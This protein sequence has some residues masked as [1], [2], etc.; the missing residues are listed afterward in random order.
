MTSSRSRR[1]AL[2]LGVL[3]GQLG[4]ARAQEP[5]PSVWYRSSE[6]C[7]DGTAF[8]AKLGPR[9]AGARLATAGDRID[10][11]VTLGTAAGRA[12]G[13]LERQTS[14]G[15]VAIRQVESPRCDD[16]ADALSLTL[17][18]ALG[19][20]PAA[21]APIS[22]ASERA[23]APYPAP[24]AESAS[25]AAAPPKAAVAPAVAAEP[26][27]R[28]RGVG[29]QD[30]VARERESAWWLGTEL[31][32]R[33]VLVRGLVPSAGLFAEYERVRAP[34][35]GASARLTV[36][37][38]KSFGAT[39]NE[40]DRWLVTSRLEAC[41]VRFS[42]GVVALTPCLGAEAGMVD[43]SG[44][45]SSG[46][47]DRGAWVALN[48]GGRAS[49]RVGRH[50]ALGTALGVSLPF[51]RYSLVASSGSELQEPEIIGFYGVIQGAFQVP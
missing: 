26:P 32:A 17:T 25:T 49:F 20:D 33:E 24:A 19:S 10:F 12:S 22:G 29:S 2:W 27:A 16:V 43:A 28:D 40:L 35:A 34:L 39:E 46:R 23:P 7:P 48:A 37:F 44:S 9:A 6:G 30:P 38:A 1:I 11:V 4:A 50:A 5:G 41:P 51:T 18:L 21:S 47:S 3:S 42:E 15:I 45:G 31:G 14:S 13:V 8:L 36:Q